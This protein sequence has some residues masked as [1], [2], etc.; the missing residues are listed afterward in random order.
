MSK[1]KEILKFNATQSLVER[2]KD[3]GTVYEYVV[4]SNYNDNAPEGSKWDWGHY[5][6]TMEN[7]LKY[8]VTRCL[9]PIHRYVLIETDTNNNIEER[10]YETYE[11]ARKEFDK[12]F[13]N[14]KSVTY[15]GHAEIVDD[16][17]GNT[18]GELWFDSDFDDTDIELKIIDVIV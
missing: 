3:D 14:Y 2:V 1:S 13:E 11:E 17:N 6:S 12:R 8:I 5:F 10:T 18:V 15:C 7:A 16:G 9:S 4:C